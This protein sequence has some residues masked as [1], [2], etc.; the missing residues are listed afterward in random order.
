MF[1]S[2]GDIIQLS[3]LAADLY[4]KG[5][6]V[7][8]EAPQ[9]FR[10]LVHELLL[11]KDVLFI[12]N[13]KVTRDD[14]AGLYEFSILVAKYENLALSDRG[15]WYRRLQW[16]REQDSIR[17]IRNKLQKYQQLL[18]LVLTPE[19]RTIL[20]E[21]ST[22]D[23]KD[24][25][26]T[27]WANVFP[28]NHDE[29]ST[30]R[31]RPG[32]SFSQTTRTQTIDTAPTLVNPHYSPSGRHG[33]SFSRSRNRRSDPAYLNADTSDNLAVERTLSQ[34]TGLSSQSDSYRTEEYSRPPRSS[35]H[36]TSDAST[37]GHPRQT[38]LGTIGLKDALWDQPLENTVFQ[39]LEIPEQREKHECP[40]ELKAAFLDSFEA[41]GDEVL[42]ESWIR[43]ATWWLIKSQSVFR[44]LMSIT[45]HSRIDTFHD[46]SRWENT[47]SRYQA[48]VD[49]LKASWILEELIRK[50]KV[51]GDLTKPLSRKLVIDLMKALRSD[52]HHRQ[53]DTS[54]STI[55]EDSLLLKQDLSLLE[56]FEQTVEAKENEPRAMD[57][58]TTSQRWITIDKD[59]GGFPEEHILFRSFVNAQVGQRHE[60]SKSSNAPY[61][62]LLWTKI[63]ES[64]IMVSLCNQR[65]TMNLSRKVT[66]EDLHY[67]HQIAGTIHQ[68]NNTTALHLEFPSQSAEI[69]FLT[70][71]DFKE[72]RKGP[73]QFF[74]AVKERDPRPGELTVFQTV[75]KS[76]RNATAAT[77]TAG[78][79]GS[80]SAHKSFDSCELRLYEQ[81]DD[82]CWKST[83]RLVISSAA[84]SKNL[85]SV[86]YW[87]PI[88]NVRLQ[89]EDMTVTISWSDCAHLEKRSGGNYNPYY[90]YVYRPD[91]PNQKVILIFSN[92][93]D[94]QRFEDCILF[95]T[96]T[97]PQVLLIGRINSAT[98]FQ[99][100]RIYSLYDQ[101][102]PDRGYHGV[103]YAKK[104]PKTYH[105]SQICYIYRDL[106]FSIQNQ[107]AAEIELQN[108]RA[109]HY[110]STRHKMLS[111]P[112][113]SDAPPECREV[114]RV[115]RPMQLSFSTG[116]DAERFLKALTGWRLK[117]YR[118]CAKLVLIDTSHFRKPKK[119]YKNAGILLWEK[120]AL[121]TGA[122]TQLLIRLS[123][124]DRP[125]ITARLEVTGGGLGL[126][127][128]GV[129]ELKSLAIQQGKDLDRKH[130]KANTEE[131]NPKPCWKLTIMFTVPSDSN[132]FMFQSGLVRNFAQSQ[133]LSLENSISR[134]DPVNADDPRLQSAFSRDTQASASSEVCG[135]TTATTTDNGSSQ[136]NHMTSENINQ[137]IP[138]NAVSVMKNANPT[139]KLGNHSRKALSS[140][141]AATT[142]KTVT[143]DNVQRGFM[144]A[145]GH[146]SPDGIRTNSHVGSISDTEQTMQLR[147]PS[148][149]PHPD[150]QL[151]QFLQLSVP[152]ILAKTHTVGSL[153]NDS[154]RDPRLYNFNYVG[155]ALLQPT[156]FNT[157][158]SLTRRGNKTEVSAITTSKVP[159]PAAVKEQRSSSPRRP[160]VSVVMSSKS[161]L[162]Q[163]RDN[164]S[165]E[166]VTTVVQDPIQLA[167]DIQRTRQYE[168]FRE[169]MAERDAQRLQEEWNRENKNIETMERPLM[170]SVPPGTL[171]MNNTIR[172]Q[173]HANHQ[174][175]QLG[176]ESDANKQV[177]SEKVEAVENTTEE[178]AEVLSNNVVRFDQPA[179]LATQTHQRIFRPTAWCLSLLATLQRM[180]EAPIAAGQT[181]IRWNCVSV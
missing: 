169:A 163:S 78:S 1:L 139:P 86:S 40:E 74:N 35:T 181:R 61:V 97:P 32:A 153:G 58:F 14:G 55:P 39:P 47:T 171:N 156:P 100:T 180:Q 48:Y 155:Q 115:F 42:D 56:S 50:R 116:D 27:E 65:D 71:S 145:I 8:R 94:A 89:V 148:D 147:T 46:Y 177:T 62:I 140:A 23:V 110:I 123:E 108:V 167:K 126:P 93:E 30:Y 12:V 91:V 73:Q 21:G 68:D 76:Y 129:A 150:E 144:A 103:V 174:G 172:H 178:S 7:A 143:T 120:S 119:T 99:E 121:E 84:D 132:D 96:E 98:A 135:D 60:R 179:M 122:I 106:D 154:L 134:R 75:L 101:E 18:Q 3:R 59:H 82:T 142:S 118:Q 162:R 13:R 36:R 44:S 72:F 157:A 161:S 45:S 41:I 33:E 176:T 66:P 69:N 26:S 136:G 10:D 107:N 131:A 31:G 124:G 112:K 22:N 63:G 111:R 37:E 88:S 49:L 15:H 137:E 102:D 138:N 152:G 17:N 125:W 83:R 104:S 28:S 51:A 53:H 159:K 57:D 173:S 165:P 90:S 54:P 109:P 64:E 11:L 25:G 105:F 127:T 130:M 20:S 141:V 79:P 34:L 146:E 24:G 87:L 160:P 128:G 114:T 16:T 149:L 2:V 43:I 95:L 29:Q 113:D 6:V 77:L 80:D 9:E 164:R 170:E 168:G 70:A 158:E 117:F 19:G 133:S 52:L 85:G 81:T 5:W 4:T 175:K 67:D 38:S 151:S 92:G 166:N